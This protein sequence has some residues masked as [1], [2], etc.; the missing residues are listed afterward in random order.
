M[1]N[2]NQIPE[3]YYNPLDPYHHEYDNKPLKNINARI[4]LIN[5]AVD[6]NSQ[7]LRD[8]AGTQGNVDTRISQS[9]D[10]DGNL[11]VDAID[12][13]LHHI[14]AHTEGDYNGTEYAIMTQAE[15]DKLALISDD[16][17]NITIGIDT[18]S[19]TVNFDDGQVLIQNSDSVT[20]EVIS[21]NIVKAH[22]GFPLEA[23]HLHY[24]DLTPSHAN[25]ITPNYT[26]YKTT[27][28]STPF[29]E[30]SLRV[31][32]NGIRIPASPDSVYVYGPDGPSGTWELTNFVPNFSAGTFVLNRA[33]DSTDLIK[34]D[35][36]SEF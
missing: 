5:S 3:V 28:L 10:V 24:Y 23:A 31:Y 13:T 29:L 20:W 14:G 17:T 19:S 30:D 1:P 7:A 12:E 25:I 8:A 6:N 32:I 2:I 9:I 16:A 34:I 4:E 18:I 33:I 26:N 11:R 36:D 27:S 22:L 15:R 35:F 21:P